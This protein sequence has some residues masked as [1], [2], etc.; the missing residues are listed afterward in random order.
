MMNWTKTLVDLADQ[1]DTAGMEV[2]QRLAPKRVARRSA[3]DRVLG[4]WTRVENAL[5]QSTRVR[6]VPEAG[7]HLRH[8]G[9]NLRIA[10][11]IVVL[12]DLRETIAVANDLGAADAE[13]YEEL[14]ARAIAAA[15]VAA[16]RG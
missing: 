8:K 2:P 11:V 10:D 9:M 13:T 12:R 16:R 15:E 5:Y 14:A 3:H 4:A 7:R 6:S 1:A